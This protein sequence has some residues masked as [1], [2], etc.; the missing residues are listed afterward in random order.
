M[1]VEKGVPAA[2][3]HVFLDNEATSEHVARQFQRLKRQ[4]D[5]NG[6]AIAIG[7]PYT[8]TLDYLEE[9]LPALS[10]QGYKLV[11]VETII[12]LQEEQQLDEAVEPA[13]SDVVQT[14]NARL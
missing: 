14:A 5:R 11:S 7:H 8:V 4:A 9:V 13:V 2:R 3:R 1:A 12:N 6:Y 10:E